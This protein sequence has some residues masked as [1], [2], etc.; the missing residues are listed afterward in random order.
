MNFTGSL[1]IT[2]SRMKVPKKR[3]TKRKKI[4]SHQVHLEVKMTSLQN[5]IAKLLQTNKK[6]KTRRRINRILWLLN[7]QV[8]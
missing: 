4:R 5:K 7:H 8:R 2:H 3:G 1:L 6:R